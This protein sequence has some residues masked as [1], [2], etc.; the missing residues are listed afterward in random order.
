M[1]QFCKRVNLV[2]ELR[3]LRRAEEFFYLRHNRLNRNQ[4]L[5]LHR[6]G[7]FKTHALFCD[8]LHA[9]ERLLQVVRQKLAYR[10]DA[11]VSQM[12]DVVQRLVADVD[13]N[14]ILHRADDVI[15]RQRQVFNSFLPLLELGV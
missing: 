6:L 13:F 14:Q 15:L 8:A 3:Q 10:A 4:V 12:V 7:L 11:A 1:R 9:G 5:R 2:H